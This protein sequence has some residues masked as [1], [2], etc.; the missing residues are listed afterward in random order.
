MKL[1]FAITIATSFVLGLFGGMLAGGAHADLPPLRQAEP[2]APTAAREPTS[3]AIP[4]EVVPPTP[5]PPPRTD[6]PPAGD[7]ARIPISV[8][9]DAGLGESVSLLDQLAHEDETLPGRLALERDQS[10]MRAWLPFRCLVKQH[11]I[12]TRTLS[13]EALRDLFGRFAKLHEQRTEEIIRIVRPRTPDEVER[14]QPANDADPAL[15]EAAEARYAALE[16]SLA[17]EFGGRDGHRR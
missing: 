6:L 1:F 5:E 3:S 14:E 15:V 10:S 17:L 16:E 9:S 7:Q 4:V 2:P 12:D 8:L 11:G 13:D